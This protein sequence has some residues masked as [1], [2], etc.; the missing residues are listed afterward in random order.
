M[1]LDELYR[2]VIQFQENYNSTEKKTNDLLIHE[3]KVVKMKKLDL[4]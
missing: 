4:T 3:D 1:L 2:K